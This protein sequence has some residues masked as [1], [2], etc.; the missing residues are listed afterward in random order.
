MTWDEVVAM[1]RKR[2]DTSI[3]VAL[4]NTRFTLQGCVTDAEVERAVADLRVYMERM[5]DEELTAKH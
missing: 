1:M 2:W 4:A 5:R 3:E